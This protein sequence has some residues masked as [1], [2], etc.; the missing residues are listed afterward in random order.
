VEDFLFAWKRLVA[1]L[2]L[3]ASILVPSVGMAQQVSKTDPLVIQEQGSF[4]VGGTVTT[5]PGT[6]DPRKPLAP[7]GQTYHGD[8]VF[9]FYQI[10]VNPRKF[11]I[12]MWHGAGQFSKTR[13]PTA[14]GR[15]IEH[16]EIAYSPCNLKIG[17]DGPDILGSQWRFGADH[18]ALIPWGPARLR[19]SLSIWFLHEVLL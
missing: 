7:T 2:L 18:L 15:E 5:A 17:P 11:P 8:H 6:F 3:S 1:S 4:A 12:G 9:A 19:L 14:D 16:G 13:G 10:P